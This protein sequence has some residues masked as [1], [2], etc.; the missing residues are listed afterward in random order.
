MPL[1]LLLSFIVVPI[2]EISVIDRIQTSLGWPLTLGLL[3]LDSLV[4]A[5]LVR[6]EGAR[7]WRAFR[8]A[9][10][11]GRWPGDEVA[12]G[13]MVLIG[14][15]LLLTPGFVTDAVGLALVL[16]PSRAILSKVVRRRFT[17]PQV[18]VVGDVFGAARTR[19]SSS[20]PP[21]GGGRGQDDDRARGHGG[22]QEDDG[23]LDV[24][25]VSIER[26]DGPSSSG[27][28]DRPTQ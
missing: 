9:L 6:R 28:Q 15:A 12:Q 17:P 21:V 3:F 20:T 13:A 26:E 5:V 16:P 10:A 18:R 14:G 8:E 25:V 11:G 22:G 23:V 4:G 1:L 19:P 7:T 24:E 2:V 27:T